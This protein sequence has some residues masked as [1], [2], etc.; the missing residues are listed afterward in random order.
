[1]ASSKSSYWGTRQ[2][3]AGACKEHNIGISYGDEVRPKEGMPLN[4]HDKRKREDAAYEALL[5]GAGGSAPKAGTAGRD[6][7]VNFQGFKSSQR[8][9]H[10]GS[11][12]ARQKVYGASQ[13]A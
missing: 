11:T 13:T 8:H 10:A 7:K 1:M 3:D 2:S 12:K 9:Q 4:I 5:Y 6:R